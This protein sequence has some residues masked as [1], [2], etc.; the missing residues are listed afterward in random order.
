MRSLCAERTLSTSDG[1]LRFLATIAALLGP[2]PASFYFFEELENGIHPTRLHL[3]LQLI[4]RNL[5]DGT[6]QMIATTHSSQLLRLVNQKTLEYASL[7]YRLEGRA[8]AQVM[9]ILDI[10]DA[11]R[12]ITEQ[13][14]GRLHE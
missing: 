10:P 7:T 11:K 12:V 1:T 3:L 5:S 8:D 14:L 6:T 9:R 2:E 13:S 4:E